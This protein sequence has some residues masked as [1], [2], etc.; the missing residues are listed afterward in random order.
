MADVYEIPFDLLPQEDIAH[1]KASDRVAIKDSIKKNGLLL[2]LEIIIDVKRILIA[3]GNQRLRCLKELGYKS[4]PCKI[5]INDKF[6]N[7]FI[8]K[9]KEVN[10]GREQTEPVKET[11]KG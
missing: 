11:E 7:E 2:P 5:T 9:L 3:K 1:S 10:N 4:A 8:K 6:T